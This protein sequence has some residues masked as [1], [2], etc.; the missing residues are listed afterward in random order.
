MFPMQVSN[1]KQL[2]SKIL[3]IL[4]IQKIVLKKMQKK[5]IKANEL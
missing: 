5:K 2:V 4:K 3:K 1:T